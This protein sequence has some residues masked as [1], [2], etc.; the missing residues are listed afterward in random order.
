MKNTLNRFLG[1]N[2]P[3][4]VQTALRQIYDRQMDNYNFQVNNLKGQIQRNPQGKIYIGVWEAD[5]H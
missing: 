1:R 3:A 2:T 5:F 4:E